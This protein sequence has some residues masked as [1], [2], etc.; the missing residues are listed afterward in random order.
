MS[1]IN[2]INKKIQEHAERNIKKRTWSPLKEEWKVFFKDK[3]DGFYLCNLK[4]KSTFLSKLIGFFQNNYR[5]TVFLF[6][7][8][9]EKYVTLEE[10][11]IIKSKY[12]KIYKNPPEIKNTKI[13][14]WGSANANG[15]NWFDF[16]AY[17]G[18]PLTIYSIKILNEEK[19]IYKIIKESL[20]YAYKSYD[21]TGLVGWL[22]YKYISKIFLFLDDPKS[23][24]CSEFCYDI[25]KLC[26][27]FEIADEE[28][29]GPGD[30]HKKIKEYTIIDK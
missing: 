18:N 30:I 5:H 10:I 7:G 2:K 12:L 8:E 27:G 25:T 16:S 11:N 1:I 23:P 4:S 29:P 6:K 14:V 17:Q 20:K 21:L 15:L 28:N 26:T 22:L 3:K 19:N 9:L 13:M 24:F